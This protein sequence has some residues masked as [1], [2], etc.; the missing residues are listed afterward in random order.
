MTARYGVFGPAG[1]PPAIVKRLRGQVAKAMQAPGTRERLVDI[2]FDGAVAYMPE[3]FPAI[4]ESDT[5]P[6]QMGEGSRA[7]D[8]LSADRPLKPRQHG[9]VTE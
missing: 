9:L 7:A 4:V 2:G 6:W 8:E 3:E 1:T 5:A